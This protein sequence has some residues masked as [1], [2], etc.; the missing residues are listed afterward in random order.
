MDYKTH[1]SGVIY[2]IPENVVQQ[3]YIWEEEKNAIISSRAI[4]LSDFPKKEQYE[5]LNKILTDNSFK[6]LWKNNETCQLVVAYENDEKLA[7]LK[8]KLKELDES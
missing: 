1:H 3:I 8:K 5:K 7:S 6:I 4:Y 2:N